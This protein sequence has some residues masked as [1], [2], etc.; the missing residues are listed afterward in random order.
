[1]ENQMNVGKKVSHAI[2]KSKTNARTTIEKVHFVKIKNIV[3]FFISMFVC[4]LNANHLL[5]KETTKKESLFCLF[6]L[7]ETDGMKISAEHNHFSI[8]TNMHS[9]ENPKIFCTMKLKYMICIE[10][11]HNK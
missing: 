3:F 2:I 10:T 5:T 4:T 8:A 11:M 6:V 9:Q 7:L 1:M